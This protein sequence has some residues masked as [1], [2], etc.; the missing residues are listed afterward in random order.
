[1]DNKNI[2]EAYEEERNKLTQLPDAD[3]DYEAL[4]KAYEKIQKNDYTQNL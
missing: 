1:M 3:A 4:S 2:R